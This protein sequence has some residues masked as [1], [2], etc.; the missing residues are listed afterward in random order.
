MGIFKR[1]FTNSENQMLSEAFRRIVKIIQDHIDN[2]NYVYRYFHAT[3]KTQKEIVINYL[4]KMLEVPFGIYK[5]ATKWHPIS[6]IGYGFCCPFLP[7]RGIMISENTFKEGIDLL[8]E[9]VAHE[10]SHS[11]LDTIDG[12]SGRGIDS[13]DFEQC[14]VDAWKWSMLM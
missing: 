3:T 5:C 13:E 10:F 2:P 14:I 9:I 12:L 8:T 6:W 11:K 1:E 7:G 4:N